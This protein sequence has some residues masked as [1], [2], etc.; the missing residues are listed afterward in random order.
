M[1]KLE[2]GDYNHG[3]FTDELS[4]VAKDNK[5]EKLMVKPTPGLFNK[6]LKVV[7]LQC[8]RHSKRLLKGFF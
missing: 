4:L 1:R 3:D 2:A 8:Q 6:K 5:T 7:S